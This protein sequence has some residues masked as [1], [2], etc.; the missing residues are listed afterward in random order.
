LLCF[1]YVGLYNIHGY[2][3]LKGEFR[4]PPQKITFLPEQFVQFGVVTGLER[5]SGIVRAFADTNGRL[6]PSD[7]KAKRWERD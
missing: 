1:I 7:W 2:L 3:W 6:A 5:S 4:R